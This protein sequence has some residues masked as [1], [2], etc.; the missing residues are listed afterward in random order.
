MSLGPVMVG[1]T[2]LEL[3]PEERDMLLHPMV[4]G[5][6]LFSRNYEMVEQLDSLV[7]TIHSLRDPRLLIA[8]DQEGGRVQRFRNGFTSL[9]AVRL[10]GDIYDKDAARARH[11]AGL[12]GWLMATELAMAGIDISFAP[13]LDLDKGI[14]QVIGDRAFHHDPEVVADLGHAYM[15]G[16]NNAGMMATGKHFPGHGSVSGDSHTEM[17][18]DHRRYED[19]LME[20]LIPFERMIH[21]GMAGVMLAHVIYD[22]IDDRPAGFSSFW[23]MEV[24]RKRL[25]FQGVVFSDDLEM[26]GASIAGD[27]TERARQALGAGCDM[28]LVCKNVDAMA[29]VLE[30]IQGWNNPASRLRIVRMHNNRGISRAALQMDPKWQQAVREVESY[31]VP[32]TLDLV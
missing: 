25:A 30:G 24:L 23:V 22:R 13:V 18:C 20:D 29:E 2:G 8:V 5:V 4:G 1:I 14:S 27:I 12:S 21:Y 32:H 9:P 10:L 19:I 26:A 28:V 3:K 11:L 15:H 17:P 6:I 7:A 31:D 16:M